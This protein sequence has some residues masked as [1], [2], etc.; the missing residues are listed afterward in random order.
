MPPSKRNVREYVTPRGRTPRTQVGNLS[1]R[2]GYLSLYVFE[3]SP[4]GVVAG[5]VGPEVVLIHNPPGGRHGRQS[6]KV[7]LTDLTEDDLEELRRFLARSVE[8]ALPIVK[9]R[10]RV[11][12]IAAADGDTTYTRSFASAPSQTWAENSRL[13]T[14]EILRNFNPIEPIEEVQPDDHHHQP[15]RG[16]D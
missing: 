5:E 13:L 14:S 8:V 9:E 12:A 1:F 2:A 16:H 11:A 10:D 6:T 3:A 4:E 7:V 15:V